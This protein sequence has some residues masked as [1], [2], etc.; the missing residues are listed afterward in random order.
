MSSVDVNLAGATNT[1]SSIVAEDINL[2]G[3]EVGDLAIVGAVASVAVECD[4]EN[5]VLDRGGELFDR[6]VEDSCA[7]AIKIVSDMFKES[8]DGFRPTCSQ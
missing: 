6:V 8:A 1:I 2:A 4:A 5:L 7:L 3:G